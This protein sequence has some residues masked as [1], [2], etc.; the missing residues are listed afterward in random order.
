MAHCHWEIH[1]VCPSCS[2][3]SDNMVSA[4]EAAS[5]F[6]SKYPSRRTPSEPEKVD[7]SRKPNSSDLGSK[8][9][10]S[11]KLTTEK[12]TNIPSLLGQSSIGLSRAKGAAKCIV[13]EHRD[14]QYNVNTIKWCRIICQETRRFSFGLLLNGQKQTTEVRQAQIRAQAE[15]DDR[16]HEFVR[17]FLSLFSRLASAAQKPTPPIVG[18]TL[19]N[20]APIIHDD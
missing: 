18:N 5:R 20:L 7:S 19:I 17:L 11:Q 3:D 12:I 1:P 2:Q 8:R 4:S 15:I 13:Q 16:H 9:R 6:W 14:A 10:P